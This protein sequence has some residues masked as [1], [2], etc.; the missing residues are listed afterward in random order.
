MMGTDIHQLQYKLHFV[1][2][3]AWQKNKENSA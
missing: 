2:D 1:R 3:E